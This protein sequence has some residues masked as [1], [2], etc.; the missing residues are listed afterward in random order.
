MTRQSWW[1]GARTR[2]GP[3]ALLCGALL[4]GGALAGCAPNSGVGGGTAVASVN[5]HTIALSDFEQL[6]NVYQTNQIQQTGGQGTTFAW[7]SPDGRTSATQAKQTTMEF[8]VTLELA[9]EHLTKPLNQKDLQTAKSAL[10]KERQQVLSQ[11]ASAPGAKEFADSLTPDMITLLAEQQV[12]F[13]QVATEPIF[14]SAHMRI[15]LVKTQSQAESLEKQV[16][17]GA[18][19]GQLAHQNNLDSGLAASNGDLPQSSYLVG[20]LGSGSALAQS[21]DQAI[22]APGK[23]NVKYAIVSVQGEWALI[24]VT[25]RANK[26]LSQITDANTEQSAFQSWIDDVVRP[27]AQVNEYIALS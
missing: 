26:P 7:Q 10:E 22:F 6:L 9:R 3:L 19:F 8:L 4:L 2:R 11:A 21:I 20:E 23:Q 5:G 27:T 14:P 25:Q 24:E 16:E 12:I 17:H 15:I 13:T 18:D 1:K